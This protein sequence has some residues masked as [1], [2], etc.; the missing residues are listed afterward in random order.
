MAKL[1]TLRSQIEEL[2]KE[3]PDDRED[4]KRKFDEV[5]LNARVDHMMKSF[6]ELD[7]RHR[8]RKQEAEGD[9]EKMAKIDTLRPSL[10]QIKA[11]LKGA[12]E[13]MKREEEGEKDAL[14]N[15]MKAQEEKRKAERS[16]QNHPP[17]LKD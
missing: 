6:E 9:P 5:A 3:I 2:R 12:L 4:L 10:E 15:Y 16:R 17:R 13:A 8:R 11:G 14:K 1:P 7:K